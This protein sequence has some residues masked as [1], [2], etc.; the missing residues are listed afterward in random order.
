MNKITENGT[1]IATMTSHL[2]RGDK[3][4]LDCYDEIV[5][6]TDIAWNWSIAGF[7]YQFLDRDNE[8][9]WFDESSID[10]E[11][12]YDIDIVV[13]SANKKTVEIESDYFIGQE[14]KDFYHNIG[15]V[16]GIKYV[17]ED[18][19]FAY[20]VEFYYGETKLIGFHGIVGV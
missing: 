19:V 14:V 13:T 18:N 4:Y 6:I 20:E 7:I 16:V 12:T 1:M 10:W 2:G 15:K 17:E 9:S 11:K 8:Y 3:V 5:E